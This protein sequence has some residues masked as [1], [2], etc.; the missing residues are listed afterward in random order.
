MAK[1]LRVRVSRTFNAHAAGDVL[2][3]PEDDHV[4]KLVKGGYF[5][6]LAVEELEP[7][8]KPEPEP[9]PAPKPKAKAKAKAKKK[10]AKNV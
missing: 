3:L 4:A 9:A 8:S 7:A 2:L 1:L 5:E 10:A 6:L